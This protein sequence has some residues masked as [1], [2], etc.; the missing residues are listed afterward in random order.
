MKGFGKWLSES[1]LGL[2][3]IITLRERTR[4]LEGWKAIEK[5]NK[6]GE[7]VGVLQNV[8]CTQTIP[9][10]EAVYKLWP[11][12][13]DQEHRQAWASPTGYVVTLIALLLLGIIVYV[14]HE[15]NMGA[16]G[17]DGARGILAFLFG[18]TTLGIVLE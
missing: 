15:L 17:A 6:I 2:T 18:I 10:I 13:E 12:Y 16:S 5:S 1:N 11:L 3:D 14:L 7:Y 4:D 9:A 8:K